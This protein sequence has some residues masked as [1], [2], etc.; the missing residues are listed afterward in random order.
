MRKKDHPFSRAEFCAL[1]ETD[2][3]YVRKTNFRYYAPFIIIGIVIILFVFI[4]MLS[5][6]KPVNISSRLMGFLLMSSVGWI[7]LIASLVSALRKPEGGR[8]GTITE[9]HEKTESY[10]D[11]EGNPSYTKVLYCNISFEDT[12]ELI[13]GVRVTKKKSGLTD[14]SRVFVVLYKN[15][16]YDVLPAIRI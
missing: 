7:F 2:S 5:S 1:S 6:D 14:G 10:L 13:N 11:S 3:A 12:G 8:Y 16:D 15:G 9:Y 4:R